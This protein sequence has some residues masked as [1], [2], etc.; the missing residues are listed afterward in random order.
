[1]ATMKT[2][3]IGQNGGAREVGTERSALRSEERPSQRKKYDK[4]G[5][6]Q[7]TSASAAFATSIQSL[8]T[9]MVYSFSNHRKPKSSMHSGM[10]GL[11]TI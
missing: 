4:T 6:P 2:Q 7:L 5:A 3:L 10:S 1:M 11:I 8:V 9:L